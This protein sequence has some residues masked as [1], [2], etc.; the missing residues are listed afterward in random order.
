VPVGQKAV[1]PSVKRS[2]NK[3]GEEN[4]DKAHPV[5]GSQVRNKPPENIEE[6]NKEVKKKEERIQKFIDHAHSKDYTGYDRFFCN[7]MNLSDA[8]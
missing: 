4:K 8:F 7:T 3:P 6:N 1:P 5:E 2:Q